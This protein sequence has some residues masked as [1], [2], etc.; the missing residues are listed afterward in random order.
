MSKKQK[1]KDITGIV[2]STDPEF[3]YT[4]ENQEE[5]VTLP[6]R[7]QNLRIWLDRKHRGGK[8]A[9]IIKGFEGT[10]EDMNS[11]A[12]SLKQYCGVGGNAKDHEII[13]QGDQRDKVLKW[14]L[15][16]GYS[17]SKLAGN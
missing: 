17:R 1:F 16:N 9:T 15:D 3:T 7:E 11:L 10:S 13:I 4:P 6:E 8:T 5:A 2:F 14:L 12:R